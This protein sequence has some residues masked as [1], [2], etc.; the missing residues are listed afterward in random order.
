MLPFIRDDFGLSYAESGFLVSAFALSLG[1]SNAPIGALADRFGPRLV[2]VAGLVLI[3]LAS[4]A[5]AYAQSYWQLVLLLVITGIIAGSYHAPAAAIIARVFP[6]SV[7]GAAIGLHITGGHLSFFITPVIGAALVALTATWRTPY[8]WLAVTPVVLGAVVWRMAPRGH[9]RPSSGSGRAGVFRELLG[10]FRLVGPLVSVSLL[11]HVGY[12]ALLAFTTLYLVDTRGLGPELAAAIFGVPQLVGVLGSPG[13]GALS[14]RLG[15]KTVILI[16]TV[17]LGPAFWALMAAPNELILLPLLAIGL[18]AAL[19]Q[20]PTE[21]YVMDS[22]P[23]HRR[24]TVLGSY[25]MLSQELGGLAAPLLGLLAGLVGI[26]SAYGAVVALMVTCSAA[27]LLA[28]RR[29]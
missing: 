26:G 28:R 10:I 5:V 27:I 14:D 4:A 3:G 15:R 29:L 11:T 17:G 19:R 7:R 12:S 9:E 24:A 18:F 13:A 21:V 6:A 2:I 25:H 1:L 8:L 22:A 20:T 23:A 16:G